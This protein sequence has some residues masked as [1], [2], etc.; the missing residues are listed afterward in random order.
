M[1]ESRYLDFYEWG[2]DGGLE[3]ILVRLNGFFRAFAGGGR[4]MRCL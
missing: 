4:T 1:L 3:N 2:I